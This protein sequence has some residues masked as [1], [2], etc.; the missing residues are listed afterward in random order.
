MLYDAAPNAAIDMCYFG[1]DDFLELLYQIYGTSRPISANLFALARAAISYRADIVL[2]RITK[3]IFNLD[4]SLLM[5]YFSYLH[6]CLAD[7]FYSLTERIRSN[8]INL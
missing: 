8:A 6:K 3:F 4:V 5:K 7:N 2:A 1:R